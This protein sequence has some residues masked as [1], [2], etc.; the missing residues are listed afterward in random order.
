MITAKDY[1]TIRERFG[2]MAQAHKFAVRCAVALRGE[3]L[4]RDVLDG[5]QASFGEISLAENWEYTAWLTRPLVKVVR[6]AVGTWLSDVRADADWQRA[7]DIAEARDPELARRYREVVSPW[8]A[9]GCPLP[10][11]AAVREITTRDRE[12][13]RD[14]MAQVQREYA[15]WARTMEAAVLDGVR[16]SR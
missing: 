13:Q 12:L 6:G 11:P 8:H 9:A 15:E 3:Q 1:G 16:R 2:G 10:M 7:Q 5:I 14:A 4:R